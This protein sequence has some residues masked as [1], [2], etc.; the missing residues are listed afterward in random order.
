[1]IALNVTDQI[2]ELQCDLS[3]S[4][5]KMPPD[6][7]PVATDRQPAPLLGFGGDSLGGR[8]IEA[9][10]SE[11]KLKP[12]NLL[13]QSMTLS[14]ASEEG[15]I[16]PL[17]V[18]SWRKY[19]DIRDSVLNFKAQNRGVRLGVVFGSI[20]EASGADDPQKKINHR[21][22]APVAPAELAYLTTLVPPKWDPKHFERMG[23]VM[24]VEDNLTTRSLLSSQLA[25]WGMKQLL[26]VSSGEEA[27][28][29][30]RKHHLRCDL[31]LLDEHLGGKLMGSDVA[32]EVRRIEEQEPIPGAKKQKIISISASHISA[33]EQGR[34]AKD[35]DN[36]LDKKEL[37]PTGLYFKCY[38]ELPAGVEREW[39]A[40]VGH[41]EDK[42]QSDDQLPD[43]V[44]LCETLAKNSMIVLGQI[45]TWGYKLDKPSFHA[46]HEWWKVWKQ[47]A[48]AVDKA[49]QDPDPTDKLTKL[50]KTIIE[51]CWTER[52]V[53]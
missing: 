31:I 44:G 37:Q 7:K 42:S 2:V 52:N 33:H 12:P 26:I 53:C 28:S 29:L 18:I 24:V 17:L 50:F 25:S 15:A 14:P 47:F 43:D 41:G 13:D 3:I 16:S 40:L 39:E 51:R 5:A 4:H 35:F 9:L 1:V 11:A 34:L 46:L 45:T 21:L 20:E 23:L 36:F 32:H 49:K 22:L 27:L 19:S 6:E 10:A 38:D 8:G 48:K 30:V